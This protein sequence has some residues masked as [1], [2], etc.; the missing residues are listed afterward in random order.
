M[1][2]VTYTLIYKEVYNLLR[3]VPLLPVEQLH[4]AFLLWLQLPYFRGVQTVCRYTVSAIAALAHS[5]GRSS[6]TGDTATPFPQAPIA[7]DMNGAAQGRNAA[8]GT[9]G[10][11][12]S[13]TQLRRRGK[14][15]PGTEPQEAAMDENWEL[16]EREGEPRDNASVFATGKSDAGKEKAG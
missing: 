10:A 6:D 16:L 13:S 1:V 8:A 12:C 5:S 4:L 14:G 7:V 15:T 9:S 11:S 2:Q 3:W